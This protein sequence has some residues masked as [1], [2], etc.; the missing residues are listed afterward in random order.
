MVGLGRQASW[1]ALLTRPSVADADG[2]SNA[3]TQGRDTNPH[4]HPGATDRHPTTNATAAT[5]TATNTVANGTTSD[6][7]ATNGAGTD[8]TTTTATDATATDARTRIIDAG[9]LTPA[10]AFNCLFAHFRYNLGQ[11]HPSRCWELVDLTWRAHAYAYSR[12][13]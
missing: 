1:L 3:H 8:G 7:T 13:L 11:I 6:E 10:R 12:G 5:S 9:K 4:L 2:D